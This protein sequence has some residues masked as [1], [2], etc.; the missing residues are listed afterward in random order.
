MDRLLYLTTWDFS[1]GASMGITRKIR[2]QIKVFTDEEFKVDYTCIKDGCV[3]LYIDDV[4]KN[5]GKV[6]AGRKI[7]ANYY[8]ARELRDSKYPF[9]YT[10]YGLMDTFYFCTLKE[11]HK[12]GSRIVVEIPTYPYDAEKNRGLLWSILFGWDKLYRN[13]IK[14]VADAIFTYSEDDSIFGVPTIKGKNGTDFDEIHLRKVKEKNNTI[15]LIAVAGLAKWHGYDR[16]IKGLGEYYKEGGKRI[17]RFHIVGAGKPIEEYKNIISQYGIQN[18]V[19]LY[20]LK[21]NDELDAIYDKCDIGVENLGFHRTGVYYA[22]TL[23]AKEY[24]AKGLPFITSLN[25]DIFQNEYFVMKVPADES[26]INVYDIINFYDS[27]YDSSDYKK[28]CYDIREKAKKI[29]DIRITMLPV[30]N[31]LKRDSNWKLGD[32]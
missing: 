13:R 31:Y 27:I 1:D 20:G 18:Y 9:V 4:P 17:V 8:L 24:A 25:L 23:K 29:C 15:D 16:L 12:N 5:L 21:Y 14:Y 11:L 32:K 26:S 7:A 30:I 2:S 28:I 6:G 19:Y 22:S 10:R 3:W